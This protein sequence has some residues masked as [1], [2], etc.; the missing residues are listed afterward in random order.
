MIAGIVGSL[1]QGKTLTM[2]QQAYA[3]QEQGRQIVSNY[4]LNK[5]YF[6]EYIFVDNPDDINEVRNSDLFLDELWIWLDSYEAKKS[7]SKKLSGV[8]LNTRRRKNNL[9]W[10]AQNKMQM[11]A[12]IRRVTD[13]FFMPHLDENTNICSVA[14]YD[15]NKNDIGEYMYDAPRYFPMYDTEQDLEYLRTA[16]K[17]NEK[18][19]EKNEDQ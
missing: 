6:P 8:L 4:Y 17:I 14:Y 1:G 15:V 2:T 12:R 18:V 9:W 7:D 11:N 10:S 5:K 16:K 19:K 13:I 3:R